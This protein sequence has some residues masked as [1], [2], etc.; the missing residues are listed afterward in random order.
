MTE[1]DG[2]APASLCSEG[3][4]PP[5]MSDKTRRKSELT[6]FLSLAGASD[7][8]SLAQRFLVDYD[9]GEDNELSLSVA[10]WRT[11]M[12]QDKLNADD[13]A[14]L[15]MRDSECVARLL[16]LTRHPSNANLDV[17]LRLSQC[18]TLRPRFEEQGF[19]S[20][21]CVLE[22]GLLEVVQ[23]RGSSLRQDDLKSLGLKMKQWKNIERTLVKLNELGAQSVPPLVLTEDMTPAERSNT[24]ERLAALL[25]QVAQTLRSPSMLKQTPSSTSPLVGA[26]LSPLANVP[27]HGTPAVQPC[28][29]SKATSIRTVLS[30]DA[31]GSLQGATSQERA[32]TLLPSTRCD[33]CAVCIKGATASNTL[34]T[35]HYMQACRVKPR[36]GCFQTRPLLQRFAD[37]L[38][39][40]RSIYRT[41][42][43]FARVDHGVL[44]C[45]WSLAK[46]LM[47]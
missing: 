21:E 36:S 11:M 31:A 14:S 20:L 13:L 43:I 27:G 5:P 8:S 23:Q 40:A 35:W 19:L 17:W 26:A 7:P 45:S 33:I 22:S 24:A 41:A 1:C 3:L 39:F 15:G 46:K 38:R 28:P 25:P 2:A 37:G 32:K 12:A 18:E 34:E 10:G 9:D 44:V 29:E 42:G 47:P 30:P 4:T 6:K 16:R